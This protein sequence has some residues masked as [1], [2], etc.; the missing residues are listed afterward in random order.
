[1]KGK[2]LAGGRGVV[3]VE[4]TECQVS[5]LFTKTGSTLVKKKSTL[6]PRSVLPSRLFS[7]LEPAQGVSL[8]LWEQVAP[9][10]PLMGLAKPAALPASMTWSLLTML[11]WAWP[12]VS[13]TSNRDVPGFDQGCP[14]MKPQTSVFTGHWVPNISTTGYCL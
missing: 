14:A 6:G 7:Q 10:Q 11:Q 8:G 2:E 9:I 3:I 12:T 4:V 5:I 1:M 13:Q